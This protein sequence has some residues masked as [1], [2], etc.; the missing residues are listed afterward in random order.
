MHRSDITLSSN[1]LALASQ[2]I[3]LTTSWIKSAQI[4]LA[5][6]L[7]AV[8]ICPY[9]SKQ[10]LA[11]SWM[12]SSLHQ[13]DS[14]SGIKNTWHGY[15]CYPLSQPWQTS[16]I[17]LCPVNPDVASKSFPTQLCSRQPLSIIYFNSSWNLLAI[18]ALITLAGTLLFLW[19]VPRT[20]ES[21]SMTSFFL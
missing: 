17:T 13:E 10:N 6:Y 4:P 1:I 5:F 2:E 8:R 7:H 12:N 16:L 18:S 14:Y 15:H 21:R 11:A 9:S 19:L 3:I 20:M